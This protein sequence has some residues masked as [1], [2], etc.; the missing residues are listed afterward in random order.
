MRMS[1]K[2]AA[3]AAP[4]E[5]AAAAAAWA[6]VD[7]ASNAFARPVRIPNAT[8]PATAAGRDR[9]ATTPRVALKIPLSTTRKMTRASLSLVPNTLIANSSMALGLRSTIRP[10]METRSDGKP[11][12]IPAYSSLTPTASSPDRSP[13]RPPRAQ[14][15]NLRASRPPLSSAIRSS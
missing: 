14:D 4:T 13:A 11:P 15:F 8:K 1:H 6:G 5:I 9:R 12:K 10:L 3:T 2:S 7:W